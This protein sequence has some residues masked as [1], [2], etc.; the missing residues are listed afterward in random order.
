[1][2][3]ADFMRVLASMSNHGSVTA[4]AALAPTATQTINMTA[5]SFSFTPST[6]TVNQGD[7]VVINLS[8]PSNDAA[9]EHG[10]LMDTYVNPGQNALRGQTKQITFKATIAGQFAFGCNVPSC[11]SG[12]SNMFGVMTVNAV[13]PNPAPT[14][15]SISPTSG[16]T[17]GGT[18]VTIT[19]TNFG[20]GATVKFGASAATNVSVTSST[21]ITAT[22]PAAS[23]TG[24]VAVSVTNSDAQSAVFNSFTYTPAGPSISSVAPNN[25]PTSGGTQITINGNGFQKGATVT[26]GGIP[27]WDIVVVNSTTITALTGVGPASEEA[28]LPA[29]VVVKNPDGTTPTLTGGFTWSIPNLAVTLISPNSGLPSGGADVTI[30]GAGFTNAVVGTVTFGGIPVTSLRVVNAVT[31]SV[32]APPHAAGAVDVVV[33]IGGNSRTV[34][35]GFI[36]QVPPPRHRAAKR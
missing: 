18:V 26:I 17:A 36:Y 16:T 25:G 9:A 12:H 14:I 1:M 2:T 4:D 29:D 15:T 19:G 22:T 10:L 32:T 6:F 11:G 30:S 33:T 5:K 28:G 35:G 21:S 34:A 24:A 8:V 23:A 3:D 20:S 27:A 7:T 31:L 13:A